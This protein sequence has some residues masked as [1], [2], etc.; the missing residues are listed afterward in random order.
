MVEMIGP[1][2]EE[3][4]EQAVRLPAQD[5]DMAFWKLTP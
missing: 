2:Y 5:A 3:K 4:F 1:F